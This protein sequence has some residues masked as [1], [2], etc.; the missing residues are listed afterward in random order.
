MLPA[1]ELLTPSTIDEAVRMKL[2]TGGKYLAGGTDVFVAMHGAKERYATLIDLKGIEELKGFKT[3]S[4]ASDGIDFGALTPHRVFEMN[5]LIKERYTALFEGCSGVGSPQIRVRGTVGGNIC[6]AVPSADS[7]GPLLVFNAA[8]VFVGEEGERE[9][10]LCEFFTGARKTVL[11]E[12]GLLKRIILPEPAEKS[13]S[14][15]IKYTRREAMDLALFGVSCYIALDKDHIQ[16]ARIAL[17]TAAPTPIRATDAEAFLAGRAP[18]E[19]EFRE[20]ADLAATQARPRS[21]WRS[22]AEFR[23]ALAKEL[24]FRA[25]GLAAERARGAVQ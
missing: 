17:T 7:V 24:T 8:C 20:A 9:T 10:P 15:Y 5:G 18:G 25:I 16:T 11:G 4:G 1:F 22:S 6:N 23:T 19:A 21:S 3:G 12:N 13:G 14:A 2:E